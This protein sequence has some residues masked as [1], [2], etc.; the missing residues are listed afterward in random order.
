MGNCLKTV[1]SHDDISLL[2]DSAP[3]AQRESSDHQSLSVANI[4]NQTQHQQQQ[5][6]YAQTHFALDSDAGSSTATRNIVNAILIGST[7]HPQQQQVKN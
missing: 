5:Q 7:H 1:S 3:T 6:N 2:R 4:F